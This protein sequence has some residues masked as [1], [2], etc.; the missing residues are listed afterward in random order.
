MG[1]AGAEEAVGERAAHALVEE[2]EEQCNAGSLI[3]EAIGVAA[4]VA[5]QQSVGFEFVQIVAQLGECVVGGRED[6][7][8]EERLMDLG[9]APSQDCGAGVQQHLHEA[10]HA[11]VVNFD[12]GDFA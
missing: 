3:G 10:Q 5:L 1:G 9:G 7:A 4:T 8:G 12:A 11:G 6:E 2:D